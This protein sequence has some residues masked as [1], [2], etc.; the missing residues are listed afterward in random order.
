[1][2]QT[3]PLFVYFLSFLK[4]MTN[5]VQLDFKCKKISRE[6]NPGRQ[7]KSTDESTELWRPPGRDSVLWLVLLNHR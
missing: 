4:T 7:E 1:M 2:G 6:L 5:I 3:R